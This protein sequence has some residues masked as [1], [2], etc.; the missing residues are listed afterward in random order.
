M[1]DDGDSLD[2]T[3]GSHAPRHISTNVLTNVITVAQYRT[4]QDKVEVYVTL[5]GSDKSRFVQDCF[6]SVWNGAEI[7]W[8]MPELWPSKGENPE[9]HRLKKVRSHQRDVRGTKWDAG[10][11]SRGATGAAGSRGS[12]AL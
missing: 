1:E 5:D 4:L 6:R 7:D 3:Y 10:V 9:F 2:P 12:G 11:I 8:D